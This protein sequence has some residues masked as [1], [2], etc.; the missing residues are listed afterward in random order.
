MVPCWL[1]R[2][3]GDVRRGALCGGSTGG[4]RRGVEPSRGGPAVRHRPPDGEE[5]A[6]LFGAAGLPADEACAA[7]E[8]GRVQRHRRRD[9]G[10][11]H[12]SGG[13]AQAAA[14]GAPDLRVSS[15]RARVQRRLHHREGLCAFPAAVCARGLRATAPPAGPCPGRLRRGGGGGR[16]QAG[17]GCL[18]LPDPAPFQR[19][20]RQGLSEGDDGGLPRRPCQRLRL[21][22]RGSALDPLRQHHPCGGA[23]P[24]GRHAPQ[25]AGVLTSS[26]ALPVP[27]PLRPA[28]QGQRQGQG[29]SPGEDGTAPVHG[30]DPEGA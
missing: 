14:H 28:R 18:L 10:G 19:L 21:P 9:P 1:W 12:G 20:V 3:A 23:D 27:R 2:G 29:R 30:A 8:A 11:G 7:A 4:C 22:R 15:R 6:E 25:D 16:G 17:E 24:G 5:D 26:V 13:A